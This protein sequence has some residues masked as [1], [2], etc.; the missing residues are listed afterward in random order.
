MN[1]ENVIKLIQLKAQYRVLSEIQDCFPKRSK[2][3]A[4]MLIGK[5][6]NE[7]LF[8]I[9]LIVESYEQPKRSYTKG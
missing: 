4:S 2:H 7:I 8:Q 5:K 6:M 9:E 1:P 3:E